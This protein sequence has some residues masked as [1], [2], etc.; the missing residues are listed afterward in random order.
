MKKWKYHVTHSFVDSTGKKMSAITQLYQVGVYA[1]VNN[2]PAW[3]MSL[4][5]NQMVT[6][7]RKLKKFAEKG[8]IKDLEFGLPITVI[9]DENGLYK[10][11]EETK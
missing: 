4:S 9:E 5:P 3:Q 6:T 8:E 7:E 10:K 1:I 2:N 11:L